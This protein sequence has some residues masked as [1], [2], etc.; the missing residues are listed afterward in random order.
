MNSLKCLSEEEL[1]NISGG[2]LGR[3]IKYGRRL[4]EAAGVYD[5]IEE[6]SEGF[7]EGW[8]DRRN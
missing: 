5:A 2:N 6:F 7:S 1:I 3:L 8:S 4:L